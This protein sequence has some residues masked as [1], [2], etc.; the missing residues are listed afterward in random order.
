MGVRR[1]LLAPLALAVAVLAAPTSGAEAQIVG[2][3]SWDPPVRIDPAADAPGDGSIAAVSCPSTSLC[4][5]VDVAG[6]VMT[7]TSPDDGAQAWSF[8]HVNGA[9]LT[10]VSCPSASLCVAVDTAGAVLTNTAPADQ[11]ASWSRTEIDE[12]AD[13]REVECA[14][15]TACAVVG[16]SSS[17]N[18][19]TGRVFTST[20]PTA[21]S[22]AWRET[23]VDLGAC[24]ASSCQVSLG[25]V[26]VSCPSLE[27]CVL[28][29]GSGHV[30]T[31]TDPF[32]PASAWQLAYVDDAVVGGHSGL[33]YQT[34]IAGVSCLSGAFCVASDDGGNV[35]RT[36]QPTGGAAA[37][38][39]FNIA[40][41]GV[42]FADPMRV[43]CPSVSRCIAWY[44][45]STYFSDIPL[46]RE[47]WE[48]QVIDP[49]GQVNSLSCPSP[50]LCVGV[51][52]AGN[53]VIGRATELSAPR[54]A[55]LLR[56]AIRRPSLKDLSRRRVR[57]PVRT[58]AGGTV[59]V[60]WR[61]VPRATRSLPVVAF[62]ERSFAAA[63]AHKIALRL[64]RTRVR[65]LTR[66]G[67]LRLIVEV[68]LSA[69]GAAPV[70]ATRAFT[71]RRVRP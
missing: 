51:D 7:S 34:T 52:G 40:P 46:L 48:T 9:R 57:V 69:P 11:P 27:L 28:G 30:A 36:R 18:F 47:P 19:G 43:T 60:R 50:T 22:G 10:D 20:T 49:E 35:L 59:R 16:G 31:S 41:L 44:G 23:T 39:R 61:I 33:T 24:P 58:P 56:R 70:S 14:S 66:G 53:A 67:R 37:W 63:G 38:T 62:G 45:S 15:P 5:A 26:S 2:P 6:N 21:G 17:L 68:R 71:L 1:S 12:Q 64:A 3:L 25:F 4:V 42:P 32:G 8:A 65:R 29:D 55:R 13:I 54:I